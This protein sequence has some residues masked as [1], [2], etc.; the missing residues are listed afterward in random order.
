[1]TTTNTDSGSNGESTPTTPAVRKLETKLLRIAGRITD[2]GKK[3]GKVPDSTGD[4]LRAQFKTA[5]VAV[6][7]IVATLAELPDN[8]LSRTGA[9]GEKVPLAAGTK[10]EIREK[11]RK[12]YEGFMEDVD[13]VGLTVVEVRGKR[14]ACD[15]P[16]GIRILVPRAHVVLEE[17]SA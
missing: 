8:V 16:S 13:L 14:V 5:T 1:M 9:S 7:E 10:V 17:A 11:A 3:V 4:E 6:K 15:T 12:G 2:Y